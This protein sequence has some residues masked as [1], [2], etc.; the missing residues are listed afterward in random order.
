MGL[1]SPIYVGHDDPAAASSGSAAYCRFRS[2][3]ILRDLR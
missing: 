3:E 2:H 1:G